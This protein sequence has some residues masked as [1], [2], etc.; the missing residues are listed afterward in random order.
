MVITGVADRIPERIARLV[1]L[2]AFVPNDGESVM[3]LRKAGGP[4]DRTDGEGRFYHP[5]TG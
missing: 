4:V 5:P 3:G 1:Y 2:D